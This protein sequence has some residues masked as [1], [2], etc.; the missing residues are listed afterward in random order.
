MLSGMRELFVCFYSKI[1]MSKS[2]TQYWY[3]AHLVRMLIMMWGIGDVCSSQHQSSHWNVVDQRAQQ[4]HAFNVVP[5]QRM[6][7]RTI[8]YLSV[9]MPVQKAEVGMSDSQGSCSRH[10]W[11]SR[12]QKRLT[13]KDAQVNLSVS[14]RQAF[15]T[16]M[17][18]SWSMSS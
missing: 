18:E 13:L 3:L 6:C 9:S 14:D 17:H 10:T 4:L 12:R 7:C 2:A 16:E 11:M 15:W 8:I 1:S 5:K